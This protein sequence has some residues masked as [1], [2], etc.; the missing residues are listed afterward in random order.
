MKEVTAEQAAFMRELAE[1][2]EKYGLYVA[3]CGCCDSPCLSGE[4]S[5]DGEI[6]ELRVALGMLAPLDF[7]IAEEEIRRLSQ[8][9]EAAHVS[10]E[11][12]E[13]PRPPRTFELEDVGP[14]RIG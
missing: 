4:P 11:P 8:E 9:S 2:E 1:L 5:H 13:T 6:G 3:G 7:K 12:V 10:A 14:S